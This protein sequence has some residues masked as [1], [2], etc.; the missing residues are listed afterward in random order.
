VSDSTPQRPAELISQ[1]DS[2][3]DVMMNTRDFAARTLMSL[4]ICSVFVATAAAHEG[5]KLGTVSFPVSC[6]PL[7][8][9]AFDRAVAMLH[10][11]WFPQAGNEF[12]EVAKAE[13]ECAMAYW[14]VAISARANPL[15]GAPPPPAMKRGWEFVEK[16][17]AA[18]PKTQR[19]R[20]YIA[21]LELYY[22]N[23]E[24]PNHQPRVLAFEKAMEQLA[25][26]YPDDVEAALFYSLALNEAI[27]ST[28]ADKTYG[29]H[30]KA[31]RIGENVL[32]KNP[33]HPGALH[34]I[35]H[36][37]DFPALANRG[38]GAANI[39]ASVARGAPHALHMP[40][41]IYS[42]L[43]MWQESIK[44]NVSAVDAAKGYVHAIDFMVYAHLQMGQDREAKR[45]LETSA[46]LQK[47]AGGLEQRS[48][49]GALLP[50]Q[51]AYAAIPA[52]YAIERGAWNEAVALPVQP[53][54]PAA[55]A[56]TH[57]TRA[58]AFARLKNPGNARKEIDSLQTLRD[59]LAKGTDPY[60][61]DQIDIQREAAQG[62][63]AFAEGN[64]AQAIK[65]MRSAADREDHTE[66]HVAMENRLWPMRELLGEMLLEA[67]EP[68]QALKEFEASLG[69]SRNRL[70]GFYGA[71]KAAEMANNRGKAAD[72]YAKLVALTSNADSPRPEVQQAKAF[73]AAR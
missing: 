23:P 1:D 28:P 30:I 27:I 7:A 24:S 35:I 31:A 53:T 46:A 18:G 71:A 55:D 67:K 72:Y 2:Q 25:Q 57:F 17:K 60:W 44:S 45:L 48:P 4:A 39:Y 61:P 63:V 10:S 64:K 58:I 66:K 26:R 13:P 11:F 42:M 49:T 41:H 9:K 47:S 8:Q 22:A 3:G 5:E 54:S 14:G 37:Y 62:W 32:A 56:I 12:A 69:E 21:A 19:E 20:D 6:S 68:A 50:V 38:V 16:A 52:R 59:E 70:R 34:Y 65:L 15:V 51:T 73:L 43:G 40:S 33:D 36:S 29:R